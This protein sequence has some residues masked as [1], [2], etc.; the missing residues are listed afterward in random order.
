MA[1][2]S[3]PHYPIDISS[4]MVVTPETSKDLYLFLAHCFL[5]IAKRYPKSLAKDWPG[6]DVIDDLTTR[7]AGLFIWAK[8]VA[9][10]VGEGT[11]KKRLQ[12]VTN[13]TFKLG[14]MSRLYSLILETHFPSPTPDELH[15][16]RVLTGAIILAKRP[17]SRSECIPFL[18]IED[19]TLDTI[20][21]GLRSVL[22]PGDTLRFSHQSFADFLLDHHNCPEGFQVIVTQADHCLINACLDTMSMDLRFNICD[23]E[24]SALFNEDVP[25][26]EEKIE[27]GIPSHLSYSCCFWADHLSGVPFNEDLVGQVKEVVKNNFLFWLEVVSFLGEV[28]RVVPILR[29]VS[30][31]LKVCNSV[32]YLTH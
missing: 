15:F 9:D 8:T 25:D 2:S 11:P 16:F 31:W 24:S 32:K 22:D 17:L 14:D 12:D 4:G 10:F 3:I 30:Q 6:P 5:K 1:L 19:T 28:N 18:N 23:L 13:R 7:A 27:K 21:N 20:C 29:V 26:I